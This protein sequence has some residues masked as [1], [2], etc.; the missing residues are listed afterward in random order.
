M[1]LMVDVAQVE[2]TPSRH[3]DG[4]MASLNTVRNV[5]AQTPSFICIAYTHV[6][7][8][9]RDMPPAPNIGCVTQCSTS[10]VQYGRRS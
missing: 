5:E 10:E 8:I 3:R 7:I 4:V 6:N 2:S 9:G 1:R